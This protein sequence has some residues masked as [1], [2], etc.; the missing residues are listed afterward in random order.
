MNEES[1]P[2]PK[3]FSAA[4][5]YCGLKKAKKDLALV[6]SEVPAVAAGVYTQNK[7][8]AAPVVVTKEHC[9][10]PVGVRAIIA[11]SGNANACTG[12]S[13]ME[14]ARRM[15]RAVA[16]QLHCRE[17]EVL[18]ASTGVIGQQLQINKIETAA[19]ALAG[20]L[21]SAHFRDAA[22]AIMTTDTF[23]KMSARQFMLGGSTVAILG[24]T[25]G[26][27]MIAPNM[28]GDNG[29]KHATM[30]GFICTDARIGKTALQAMLSDATERSFNS[31]S[32]DGDTSTND[33]VLLLAN[34]AAG[35]ES[36]ESDSKDYAIFSDNLE[37]VCV[38][39]AQMI[40]RDG[41]GATKFIEIHVRG[42]A[43]DE[44]A[45]IAARSIGGSSLVKTAI[46]GM[47]ANWGRIAAAVGY[48][49]ID[50]IPA[51]MEI[52]LCGLSVL[53]KNYH[54][55]FDEAEMKRLLSEKDITIDVNLNGGTG[56][57]KFWTCD[58]SLDYVRINGSYRS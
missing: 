13:G 36:L 29:A 56:E 34:G 46:F 53:G 18:V 9:A 6:V 33:M 5:I 7:V 47:D 30:L 25:K 8:C 4:G 23:P 50:F 22:E 20:E 19:P 45:N 41:E 16:E 48:S 31:I 43:T 49:G 24:F 17:Q 27:G 11:N 3:G 32:V 58:L 37:S 55:E 57:A 15:A 12:E 44:S 28:I 1:F 21:S 26:S 52:S 14:N 39:L 42:A 35:N 38:E 54:S 2:V 40:V 51:D 10:Q